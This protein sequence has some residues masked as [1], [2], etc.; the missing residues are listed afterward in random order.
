MT[1]RP[2]PDHTVQWEDRISNLE[3]EAKA[4]GFRVAGN[5]TYEFGGDY[6]S[7]PQDVITNLGDS[8]DEIHLGMF[9]DVF[10]ALSRLQ[11]SY[12]D[13][14]AYADK[15][16]SAK[17][18]GATTLE[19]DAMATMEM[20][21]TSALF[22]RQKGKHVPMD[23]HSGF[24]EEMSTFAKFSGENSG[25]SVRAEL[26]K[27]LVQL[28]STIRGA[29]NGYGKGPSLARHTLDQTLTQVSFLFGFW[30]EWHMELLHMCNYTTGVAWKFIG[31]CT[32]AVM[33]HLVGPRMEVA[34]L[35]PDLQ[36][37]V[38]KGKVIWAV[39]TV[40]KR[41]QEVIAKEF[42]SHQVITTAMSGFLMKHRV[43]S[44]QMDSMVVKT[45]E[46]SKQHQGMEKFK[47]AQEATN[48]SVADSIKILKAKK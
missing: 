40:H 48:K 5:D 1:G 42:K 44:S 9:L 37:A 12:G 3:T 27:K 20:S 7:G 13:G 11:D 25:K 10:G 29:I 36:S 21:T 15:Q 45:T 4:L 47:S 6:Y 18:L 22:E 23:V 32:R 16:R 41:M 26:H 2:D 31:V 24:G 8:I 38:V 34:S 43:D 46:I 28:I 17:Y 14:K 33:D 35:G 39:L 19:V 30:S